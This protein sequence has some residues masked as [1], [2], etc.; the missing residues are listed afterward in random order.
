MSDEMARVMQILWAAPSNEDA[1]IGERRVVMDEIGGNAPLA[2]GTEMEAVDADGVPGQWLRPPGVVEDGALLYL[3]GGGYCLGSVV[4]HRSR[5]SKL[6]AAAGLPALIVD[7][8]LGP[9]H[10]FPAAV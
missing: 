10:P 8:R 2:E 4:S 5:A 3:H 1:T 9:E 7:Y 6:A